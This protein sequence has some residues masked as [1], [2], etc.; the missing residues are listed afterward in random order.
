MQ[1]RLKKIKRERSMS[2]RIHCTIS[3]GTHKR[4]SGN[5]NIQNP[6]IKRDII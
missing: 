5:I 6:G 4:L 3:L 2:K 1:T